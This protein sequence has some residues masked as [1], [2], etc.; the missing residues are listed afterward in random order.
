MLPVVTV[1]LYVSTARYDAQNKENPKAQVIN[2]ILSI[3]KHAEMPMT[4]IRTA[5]NTFI[6]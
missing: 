3:D 1:N 4:A 2:I 5:I 6:C